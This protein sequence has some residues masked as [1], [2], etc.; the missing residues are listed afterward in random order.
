M[1][2]LQDIYNIRYGGGGLLARVAGA[3]MLAARDVLDEAAETTNHDERLAWARDTI[4]D[5]Q[6]AAGQMMTAVA[7]DA[8]V[9][10]TYVPGTADMGVADATL[11][12]IV[13]R[14]LDTR[15]GLGLV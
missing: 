11:I 12:E 9:Q 15:A 6:R 7:L 13:H 10:A 14:I 1:A 8:G 2:T 3:C 5:P 4:S